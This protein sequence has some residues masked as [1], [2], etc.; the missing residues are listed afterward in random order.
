MADRGTVDPPQPNPMITAANDSW[1]FPTFGFVVEFGG[2]T[3]PTLGQA[4]PRGY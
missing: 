4:W 3:V 1:Q 2:A